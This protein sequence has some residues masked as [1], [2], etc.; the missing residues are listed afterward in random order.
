LPDLH[1]ATEKRIDPRTE[2]SRDP[3]PEA[4]ATRF[5]VPVASEIML[6]AWR[7][8]VRYNLPATGAANAMMPRNGRNRPRPIVLRIMPLNAQ[9]LTEFLSRNARKAWKPNSKKVKLTMPT[10]LA[11]PTYFAA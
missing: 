7:L 6:T 3:P 2:R 1:I 4:R 10:R 9:L 5:D 8:P 11:R